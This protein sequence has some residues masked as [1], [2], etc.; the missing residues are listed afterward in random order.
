[1]NFR[2]VSS[3]KAASRILKYPIHYRSTVVSKLSFH[4]PGEQLIV[5][6]HDEEVKT[7]LNRTDLHGSMFLAWFELNKVSKIARKLT[8]ADIPTRFTYD[9]QEKK[10]NLRNKGFAIVIIN[11]VPRDIEDQYY[12]IIIL[13]V[14]P[15]PRCF[16]EL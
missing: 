9:A 6:K 3:S 2:Y 13:N 7:V 11:Y 10:F 1:M 16:E 15:R 8:Y 4:L 14:Q 12:L 5:F